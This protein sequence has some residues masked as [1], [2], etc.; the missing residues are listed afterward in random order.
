MGSVTFQ[1]VLQIPSACAMEFVPAKFQLIPLS[2]GVTGALCQQHFISSLWLSVPGSLLSRFIRNQLVSRPSHRKC[3]PASWGFPFGSHPQ[4]LKSY[5]GQGHWGKT[6][7]AGDA[8]WAHGA[9]LLIQGYWRL[10]V[11]MF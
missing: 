3:C 8:H 5:W 9:S 6:S 11:Y 4:S 1:A 10:E 7:E 2:D